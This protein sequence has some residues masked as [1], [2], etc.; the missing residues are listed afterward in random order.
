M[1]DVED[2]MKPPAKAGPE[3]APAADAQTETA[4]VSAPTDA[5]PLSPAVAPQERSFD[6]DFPDR[7]FDEDFPDRAN[8]NDTLLGKIASFGPGGMAEHPMP[9][10]FDGDQWNA[11]LNTAPLGRVISA[12]GDAFKGPGLTDELLKYGFAEEEMHGLQN[13]YAQAIV[14]PILRGSR[15]L[16]A[17]F[18][19]VPTALFEGSTRLLEGTIH[20]LAESG[21][22][23]R[24][25]AQALEMEM[26]FGNVVPGGVVPHGMRE[27]APPAARTAQEIAESAKLRARTPEEIAEAVRAV[28]PKAQAAEQWGR[29]RLAALEAKAEGRPALKGTDETGVETTIPERPAQFLTNSEKLERDWLRTEPHGDDINRVYPGLADYLAR[30]RNLPETIARARANAV[31]AEGEEGYFGTRPPTEADLAA[32]RSAADDLDHTDF[33]KADESQVE[34]A[35]V[36]PVD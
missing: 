21:E 23:G 33:A 36:T 25:A 16:A 31:I 8:P 6:E 34:P 10:S 9:L 12:F 22:A 27:P 2:L 24:L 13:S 7:S 11:Y 17:G 4:P 20:G 15:I 1:S 19:A 5:A 3:S 28:A 26:T 18:L 14:R 35:K 32:R 29:A 30:P